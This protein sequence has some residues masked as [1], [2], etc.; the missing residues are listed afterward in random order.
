MN[1]LT[2]LA[3]LAVGATM[4][5]TLLSPAFAQHHDSKMDQAHSSPSHLMHA[6]M[7][8]MSKNMGAM[9]MTGD[10]DRDF[11]AMMA[12]HHLGAIEMAE[13]EVK[14]GKSAEL[15]KMAKKMI[16]MQK[17]E[18]TALLKHAKMKH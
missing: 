15:K 5:S 12:E 18:R 7:A 9:K 6:A 17:Q 2:S 10:I 11:A 4:G 13:I 8:K 1:K 3:L 14:H 16:A